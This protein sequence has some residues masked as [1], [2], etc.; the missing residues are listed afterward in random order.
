MKRSASWKSVGN[1]R[2]TALRYSQYLEQALLPTACLSCHQLLADVLASGDMNGQTL[3]SPFCPRCE[4]Q[5]PRLDQGCAQCAR[6]LS[7]EPNAELICGECLKRPPA[8]DQ[9]F[10][11]RPYTDAFMQWI[12]AFKYQRKLTVGSALI[13]D[14]LH[15]VSPHF[16]P[17]YIVPMP[18]HRN[19]QQQRGFNQSAFAAKRIAKAWGA[20]VLMDS[21]Y[22]DKPTP[23][24]STLSKSDRQKVL[25][26][27]FKCQTPMIN[28]TG[29]HVAIIDDIL[30]TGTSA[31][32]LANLIKSHGAEYVSVWVLTR[33][34]HH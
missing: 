22:R 17:D 24:L 30:T 1:W 26:G 3:H 15:N 8:F 12:M 4:T 14:F 28:L 33:A 27:A 16:A 6:P 11:S 31:D 13:A 9:C 29:Q 32:H 34:I 20:P 21:F 18:L 5:L 2:Q 19:R 7:Q 10:A 23:A 25:R